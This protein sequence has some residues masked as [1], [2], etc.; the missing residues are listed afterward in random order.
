LFLNLQNATGGA[1]IGTP[2]GTGTITNDD[3]APTPTPPPA[4]VS[5]SVSTPA[6]TVEGDTGTKTLTFI[7]TL[8]APSTAT[9]TVQA[10]TQDD[11]ANA[12]SDY[13]AVAGLILTFAPGETTKFVPVTIKGDTT[14]EA[15]ETFL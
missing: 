14:G 13:A 3:T 15:D 12:P 2:R 5:V 11:T 8:S 4:V 7:A 10:D 6:A 9:V 1:A